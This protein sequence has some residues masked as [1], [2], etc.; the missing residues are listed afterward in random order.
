MT[1]HVELTIRPL[2]MLPAHWKPASAKRPPSPFST[3]FPKTLDQLDAE[4]VYLEATDAFVQLAVQPDQVRLDGSLRSGVDVGH[5][6]VVLTV[7]S[8]RGT[9]VMDTDEFGRR[10]QHFNPW[11]ENLRALTLYLEGLRRADRYGIGRGQQYTG[12]LQLDP[13]TIAIGP[14]SYTVEQAAKVLADSAGVRQAAKDTIGDPVAIEELWV[15][16]MRRL[17]PD[18]GGPGGTE[19]SAAVKAHNVLVDHLAATR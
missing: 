19:F 3:E 8:P 7:V 18:R 16:A 15:M 12:F 11:K 13:G 6:G 9:M 1:A 14:G 2:V 17:H 5:P 10:G 4:L